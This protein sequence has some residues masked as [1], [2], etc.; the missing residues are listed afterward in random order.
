[1]AQERL[2]KI[3]AERGV[4]SRRKAEELIARGKV[5]VNGHVASL[6]DKADPRHDLILVA[7]KRL[8]AAEAPTYIML[9]KPRGFV[10]TMNDELGRKCVAELV[11]SVGVRVYPVGRLDRDSEGMLLLTNDGDFANA[12]MHPSTH[13]P[14]RYRVTVRGKVTDEALE[15]FRNGMMLE[16]QKTL[17]ADATVL[18]EEPERTVLEI[19]LYE[20]RNRQIRRMCEALSLD[21]IRLRRIAIG[22]VKLG[23]LAAGKWRHLAPKE[24]KVLVQATGVPQKV[25]AE[26]IKKGSVPRDQDSARRR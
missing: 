24:V 9:N 17:P 21:V 4:A 1:M 3:L 7:G 10:T 14:K 12:I 19:V 16:G 26:Y 11:Q 5:K 22:S 13:V 15:T 8:A 2:Q 20:G 18:L 25:A 6:G 23:M